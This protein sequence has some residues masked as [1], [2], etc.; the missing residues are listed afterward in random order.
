VKRLLRGTDDRGY[1]IVPSAAG[2][3]FLRYARRTLHKCCL[4]SIGPKRA[5]LKRD[6][7]AELVGWSPFFGAGFGRLKMHFDERCKNRFIRHSGYGGRR[8][9]FSSLM[10]P[11]LGRVVLCKRAS[12]FSRSQGQ[13]RPWR[14]NGVDS[15]LR[16][17]RHRAERR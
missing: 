6:P 3:Y 10:S 16:L 7:F 14:P 13:F 12:E 9:Y 8:K 11:K 15:G 17:D 2:S 5:L 4:A 1:K